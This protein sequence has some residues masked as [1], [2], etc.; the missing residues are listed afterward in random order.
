MSIEIY[1]KHLND[2][3]IK[4]KKPPEWNKIFPEIGKKIFIE[5]IQELLKYK[6]MLCLENFEFIKFIDDEY[7]F[8]TNKEYMKNYVKY[9]N[10]LASE[11]KNVKIRFMFA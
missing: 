2:L 11:L 6:I 8:S 3:K 10:S 4:N 7:Y 9:Y 1:K 5:D